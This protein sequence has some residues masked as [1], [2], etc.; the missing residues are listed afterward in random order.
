[1]TLCSNFVHK[2]ERIAKLIY[3][4]LRCIKTYLISQVFKLMQSRRLQ[5]HSSGRKTDNWERLSAGSDVAQYVSYNSAIWMAPPIFEII[6]ITKS[7][8][9]SKKIVFFWDDIF[10]LYSLL[11]FFLF[12]MSI[13]LCV[14]RAVR[15]RFLIFRKH[16]SKKNES[17]SDIDF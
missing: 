9:H 2:C 17:D 11:L 7:P 1:M 12:Y 10:D 8:Y 3:D 15:S 14:L 5:S 16:R 13:S 6:E 4:K